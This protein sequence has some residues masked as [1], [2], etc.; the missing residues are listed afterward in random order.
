MVAAVEG[1]GA[2]A[3]ITAVV[4]GEPTLG[5][6][7]HELERF[8]KREGIRKLSGRDLGVAVAQRVNGATTVA[9]A[10]VIATAV[11]IRTFATGG[12]G[13]V[14]RELPGV[15]GTM[16]RDES[17]DL[18][19]LARSPMIVVCAGAKAILDLPATWER[20]DSLG[21]PVI[22]F[23]TDEFPGF[24]TASTGIRLSASATTPRELARIA[25][26]HFA[27]G[28]VQSVLVVQPPPA[29][30]ALSAPEVE[31]AV[32]SALRR[33]ASEGVRGG[34]VTP[35]L[36][37]AV[38]QETGGKSLEVNLELLEANA[39]LAGEIASDLESEG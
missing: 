16:A 6:E 30:I 5:L 26:A 22:G 7:A 37:Q 8:L 32:E 3:A 23:G 19:E 14:H 38:S 27:L 36:L 11:G 1:A 34:A 12:I 10:L 28:R 29:S 2:V 39:R 4:C 9:A 17:A 25:R 24:L 15:A 31:N 20:L 13:G 35:Y 33:A 18:N 21:V